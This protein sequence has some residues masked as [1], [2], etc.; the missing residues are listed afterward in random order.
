MK[1]NLRSG[2]GAQL[3]R[4]LRR[5]GSGSVMEQATRSLAALVAGF[6]L[7]GFRVADTILPLPICLA[8]ALG[9]CAP[10][11]GAYIGGCLGYLVFYPFQAMEPMA[12]GL[13]VQAALCIFG[14][15]LSGYDRWFVVGCSVAF[16]ALAGFLFLLEQRFDPQMV[17]R[18]I[19]RVLVAAGGTWCFR[20]ALQ[21]KKPLFRLIFLACL[22]AGGCSFRPAG[23]PIG[24]VGACALA[25]A[26]VMS[27]MSLT[28]A[29]LCGLAM[30][31]AWGPGCATAVL[32][33][34]AMIAGKGSRVIR[35]A[36]WLATVIAGVILLRGQSLFLAAAAFG[37]PV[38]FLIPADKVFPKD[39]PTVGFPDSRMAAATQ[40]LHRL[41]TGLE[42]T[43]RERPDPETAAVFDQAAERVC[44]VC[45]GWNRCWREQVTSTVEELERAAPA[46]MT[47][48]RAER[49]DLPESF[50]DRCTHVDGFLKAV[51]REIDDLSCRRQCRNRIAEVRE[52]LAYQYSTI[53]QAL[54][55]PGE[56]RLS[57][58]KY[59]P[60]VGYRS[61]EAPEQTISGD[62]GVTFRVGKYF[63]MILCDGMGTG[64][65]AENEAICAIETLR[66]LLQVQVRPEEAMEILNGI[67]ILRDDGAF[68]TVDLVCAD[69]MS[70]EV[71]LMKWGAAPSYL[72]R[73]THVE[74][75]GTASPPP[76]IGVGEEHRPEVIKLSLAKG[77]MLV[78]LS[79][80]AATES[81]ERFLRQY[82]G[83][84]PKEVAYGVV[85]AQP[86]AE[87]DR[88]AAV[89][90]LR[91]R[92]QN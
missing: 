62:R 5:W 24:A 18:Y 89:L 90:M 64:A 66:S 72:K 59:R 4:M 82:A 79:D 70:G 69:L 2:P 3:V 35:M 28:T 77:E 50:L 75:L 32:V 51:N 8:A 39:L 54:A 15:D 52:I 9:L 86:K 27:S 45:G 10:S 85:H 81:A 1:A 20:V 43:E 11:F 60:E 13:L 38:S 65:E 46:M 55:S 80:G 40:L 36:A 53:S 91:S 84:F 88:T 6:F 23:L 87:D 17:W 92:M 44:R 22:C 49:R 56:E 31:L 74:K 71:R 21:E 47:R 83:S 57:T 12:A 63:Y 61:E 42:P 16:T 25:S 78:L 34:S 58:C 73:K 29:S 67:Y 68:A 19:L 41:G 26:A 48:G 37:I 14:E 30:D 76:G 7:A 33:L